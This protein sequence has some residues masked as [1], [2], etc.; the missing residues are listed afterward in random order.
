MAIEATLTANKEV[1]ISPETKIKK[2]DGKDDHTITWLQGTAT[3]PF[4]FVSC[5]PAAGAPISKIKVTDKKITAKDKI[6]KDSGT[7]DYPYTITV[8]DADGHL[9]SSGGDSPEA[10]GGKGVIR[11]TR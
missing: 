3:Q 4:T 6:T 5:K 9:H 1:V 7:A 8:K 10:E 2:R 11:N